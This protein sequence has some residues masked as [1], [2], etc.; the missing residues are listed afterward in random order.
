MS[1]RKVSGTISDSI[2][3]RGFQP[4]ALPAHESAFAMTVHE[5]Q[6]SE[7]DAVRLLLPARFNRVLS[8]EL[9]YTGIT[10]AR[11]ET[12]SSG[13]CGCHRRCT[14]A[15]CEPVVGLGWRLAEP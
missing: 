12:A 2:D 15:A 1:Q 10:R 3:A 4:A 14:G 11:R 13:E 7:L 5:A 6:G 8:R 9:V